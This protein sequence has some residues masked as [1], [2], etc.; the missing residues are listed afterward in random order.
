MKKALIIIIL[1][2]FF[3]HLFFGQNNEKF[4]FIGHCYQAATDGSKVDYRIENF[5]FLGYAGIWLGGDVCSEASLKYSTI[6][7]IDS[8]FNLSNDMTFWTLGNHDSRNGNWEWIRKFTHRDT[9]FAYNKNDITYIVLNTNLVLSDCY[10]V[11][12]QYNIIKNV[13]DTISE[14]SHLIVINHQPIWVDVP[15]LPSPQTYAHGKEVRYWNSNCYD[16]E[17]NF[18]NSIYPLLLNVKNKGI[19]VINIMGDMGAGKKSFDMQSVD[20]ITFL[21]CGL[22]HNSPDDLVLIFNHNIKERTLTWE[23]YNLDDLINKQ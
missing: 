5:N 9:Y 18:I 20:G 10:N 11:N 14:S 6:K 16:S 13:C 17:S 3:Y 23:F 2:L 22:Y 8:I 19:D 15:N 4:I 21:G 12:R 7:Y 1:N